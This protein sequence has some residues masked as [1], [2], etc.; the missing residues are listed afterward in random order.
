MSWLRPSNNSARLNGPAGDSKTYG[1]FTFTHGSSRRRAER[2]SRSFVNSFSSQRNLRRAASHFSG[3][4]TEGVSNELV[5]MRIGFR[6]LRRVGSSVA[7]RE[8][9]GKAV[10]LLETDGECFVA[11]Q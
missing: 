5:F 10:A 9:Q 7:D 4:A 3:E 1:L 11:R 6:S 8:E 2:R